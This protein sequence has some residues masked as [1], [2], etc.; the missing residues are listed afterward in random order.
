MSAKDKYH[1]TVVT[2]LKKDGCIILKEQVSLRIGERRLW[3]DIQIQNKEEK[4]ILVEV[5]S[6]HKIDSPVDF[7]AKVLGQNTLYR[8]IL[9]SSKQVESLYIAIPEQAYDEI[10]AEEIGKLV[11]Q[12]HQINLLVYNIEK[13][14][15]SQWISNS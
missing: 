6:Y 10:F 2:A 3:I 8:D 12:K 4:I 5:K 15:I 11:V 1:G 13:Q 14:E 7:L 9:D